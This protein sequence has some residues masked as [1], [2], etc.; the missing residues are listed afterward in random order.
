M[1]GLLDG[2]NERQSAAFSA[3]FTR[4]RPGLSEK[5]QLL[6]VSFRFLVIDCAIDDDDDNDTRAL[7]SLLAHVS[8]L[9]PDSPGNQPS[10]GRQRL[11]RAVGGA[12]G[13]YCRRDELSHLRVHRYTAAQ[14]CKL[15][16][17]SAALVST[18]VSGP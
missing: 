11:V 18:L 6:C 1:T 16:L 4:T 9:L 8:A 17:T 2:R 10:N 3:A 7:C 13:L 14:K 15:V 12:R 5:G